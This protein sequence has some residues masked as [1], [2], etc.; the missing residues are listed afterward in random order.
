MFTETVGCQEVVSMQL[1]TLPLS[2]ATQLL[3]AVATVEV[4][5]VIAEVE[6]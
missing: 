6:V 5:K 1:V 2:T 4:F 3:K